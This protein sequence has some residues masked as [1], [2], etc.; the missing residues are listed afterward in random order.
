[1]DYKK[2]VEEFKNMLNDNSDKK[3][4]DRFGGYAEEILYAKEKWHRQFDIPE[5]FTGYTNI[6]RI[7][8]TRTTTRFE[9]DLRF[10]GQ[11][12]ATIYVENGKVTISTKKKDNNNKKH[13][14]I[15]QTLEGIDWNDSNVESFMA[16]FT[17]E[18]KENSNSPELR[19]KDD[20]LL[21]KFGK[22]NSPLCNIQPVKLFEMFFEMPTTFSG[23]KAKHEK[24]RANGGHIDILTRITHSSSE[25]QLCVM[26]LK[27]DNQ[28]TT[29]SVELVMR[30]AL[31]YATFIARLLNSRSGKDW[32]KIFGFSKEIPKPI[33]INVVTIM[34]EG[35]VKE[36]FET[37]PGKPEIVDVCENTQLELYSLY[38]DEKYNFSGSLIDKIMKHKK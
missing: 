21:T 37:E 35:S 14:G 6:T 5:P 1:M 10:A 24:E 3:W 9:Y 30:Q 7:K 18:L 22:E 38:F 27:K 11:S 36:N 25:S 23:T 33:T 2:E 28:Q 13:F 12:V 29:E 31:A 16:K 19:L 17:E 20:F 26:E 15:T 4:E 32:Y 8:R 34:P